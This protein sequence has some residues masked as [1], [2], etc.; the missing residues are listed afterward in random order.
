MFPSH[1]LKSGTH[2][3]MGEN[4]CVQLK[5]LEDWHAFSVSNPSKIEHDFGTKCKIK[6]HLG[7]GGWG[8]IQNFSTFHSGKLSQIKDS[9]KAN[10]HV[11]RGNMC[12]TQNQPHITT[13]KSLLRITRNA[14]AET[15]SALP[16]APCHISVPQT[17]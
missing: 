6:L 4:S 9:Q 16:V 10:Q 11:T 13:A 14:T 2:L 15:P 12:L 17:T 5:A 8:R 1:C 7:G 3:H